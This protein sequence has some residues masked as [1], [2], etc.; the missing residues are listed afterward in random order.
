MPTQCAEN[1]DLYAATLGRVMAIIH[2]AEADAVC[3]LGDLNAHPH[4]PFYDELER[5]CAENDLSVC[6]VRLLP[7]GSYTHLNEAHN[8]TSWLDHVITSDNIADSI[9]DCKILYDSPTSN[10][11]PLFFNMSIDM[12]FIVYNNLSPDMHSIKW[13]FDH[14][15]L[16]RTFQ[17]KLDIKLMNMNLE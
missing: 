15:D 9:H 5:C 4:T 6:D 12:N 16:R 1:N 11:F 3:V 7:A 2:E 14:L 17:S 10:H 13:N 8:S